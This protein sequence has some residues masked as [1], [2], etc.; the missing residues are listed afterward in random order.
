M[1]TEV[2]VTE[3]FEVEDALRIVMRAIKIKKNKALMSKVKALAKTK[4]KA[5]ESITEG[6][7]DGEDDK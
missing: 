1:A 4:V 2:K 5:M 6:D 3:D 7:E